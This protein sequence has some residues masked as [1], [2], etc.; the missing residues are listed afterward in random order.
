MNSV[1]KII[2]AVSLENGEHHA[3]MAKA[4]LEAAACH[5]E[6]IGKASSQDSFH[7]KMQAFHKSAAES[8]AQ[9]A[10]AHI[11]CCKA[12]EEANDDDMQDDDIDVTQESRLGSSTLQQA[13]FGDD[14]SN[15]IVPDRVRGV[16]TTKDS[17]R[18]VTMVPRTGG[19]SGTDDNYRQN[20]P[21]QFLDLVAIDEN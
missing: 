8:C 5:G 13:M 11:A 17:S 18:K 3:R 6:E 9:A 20:V 12:L 1:A 4:H 10:T 7:K 21:E 19:P 16:F 2:H 14:L 15:Q